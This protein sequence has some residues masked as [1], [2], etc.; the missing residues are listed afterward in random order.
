MQPPSPPPPGAPSPAL[1]QRLTRLLPSVRGLVRAAKRLAAVSAVAAV[2][3][4]L[5]LVDVPA[6]WPASGYTV[7]AVLGLALLLVP[8]GGTLVAAY[9][10]EEVL[11]LPARLR[12]VPGQLRDVAGEARGHAAALARPEERRRGLLGFFGTVWRLRALVGET[13]G[14]WLRALA[15]ARMARLASLPF[16]LGLLAAFALSFVV[17]AAAVVALVLA[18]LA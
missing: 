4:W 13:Q 16:A 1:V 7:E 15:L 3:L 11:A 12:A 6:L 8:A 17:I 18:V 9:T 10:L 2:V 5:V 14:A